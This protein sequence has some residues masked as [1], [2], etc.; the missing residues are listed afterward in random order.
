MIDAA[1][2][3]KI[4]QLLRTFAAVKIHETLDYLKCMLQLVLS[5]A[6]GW[7]DISRE[8]RESSVIAA[9]GLFPLIAVTALS[10][11]LRPVYE[12]GYETTTAII[13]IITTAAQYFLTY[14]TALFL[15][16]LKLP[17]LVGGEPNE[18]RTS[19]YIIY[20]VGLMTLVELIGNLLPVEV[21]LIRFL[22][23]Y[24][25]IILWKGCRYMGVKKQSEAVFM[26]LVLSTIILPVYVLGW[27]FNLLT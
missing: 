12:V 10:C 25:A 19:T 2:V 7:E 23:I 5:P 4:F 14:A 9:Y 27:L 15:I 6:K 17:D 16:P 26:L 11:L 1:K 8:G 24:V 22:P 13:R 3:A 18:K 20:G 21:G